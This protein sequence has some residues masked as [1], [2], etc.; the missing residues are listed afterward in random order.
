M[1]KN[2]RVTF[3]IKNISDVINCPRDATQATYE[4]QRTDVLEDILSLFHVIYLQC[5]IALEISKW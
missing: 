4:V 5:D 1:L 2:E 3:A